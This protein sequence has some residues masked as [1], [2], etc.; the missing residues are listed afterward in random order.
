MVFQSLC[1][2]VSSTDH[3]LFVAYKILPYI[4]LAPLAYILLALLRL[5]FSKDPSLT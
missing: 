5:Q 3:E 2:C 4:L 1:S